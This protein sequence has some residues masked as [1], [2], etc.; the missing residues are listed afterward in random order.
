MAALVKDETGWLWKPCSRKAAII[1]PIIILLVALGVH[2]IKNY[3]YGTIQSKTIELD[4]SIIPD[5]IPPS[6]NEFPRDIFTQEERQ[7]GWIVVHF[8]IMAYLCATLAIV[9]DQYFVPSLEKI[10]ECLRIPTDVAGATFMAIGTSS[11][12]LYSAL[13][14][15]FIT[16]GDIGIGTVVGSAV[17]N[18]LGV[19]S[20]TGLILWRTEAT[21]DWYPI[22]RDSLMYVISVISLVVIIRNNVVVWSESVFL[23]GMFTIY[24]TIMYYNTKCESWCT[25]Q[26]DS[27]KKWWRNECVCSPEIKLSQPSLNGDCQCGRKIYLTRRRRSFKVSDKKLKNKNENL[28]D[29]DKMIKSTDKINGE[30]VNSEES[31]VF[32]GIAWILWRVMLS[33]VNLLLTITIPDIQKPGNNNFSITFLMSVLWIGIISYLCSWMV[34]IIGHTFELPDSVSGITILAAGISVPEI[35]ASVIVVRNG[36]ANMAICNLIG[37]NIFDV[38]FCL[39]VP[40][41]LKTTIFSKTG[42]LVINSSALTYTTITLLST[43]VLLFLTFIVAG[44]KLNWKVGLSCLGLYIIFLVIA[45]MCELNMFGQMNPPPCAI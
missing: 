32:G 27:F 17:F 39:G 30:T 1:L 29:D 25:E 11:P 5:C 13:I 7:N 10:S 37:S 2:R 26:M 19:T 9:C 43:V 35:I 45:C 42:I 21:V 4:K 34:T 22:S 14:G 44:W 3:K 24:I 41:L 33:P 38:L 15:S 28:T 20:V 8:F 12:E 36:M 40:W 31:E 23:I 18:I 16:E 6:I